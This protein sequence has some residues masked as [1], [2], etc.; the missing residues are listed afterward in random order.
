[1]WTWIPLEGLAF[2][3]VKENSSWVNLAKLYIAYDP[4]FRF[5]ESSMIFYK[6]MLLY[7]M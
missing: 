6:L 7:L 1:M 2:Y 3:V 5:L 4:L